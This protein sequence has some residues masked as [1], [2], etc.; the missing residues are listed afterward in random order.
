MTAF[1]FARRQVVWTKCVNPTNCLSAF[2]VAEFAL[3]MRGSRTV[4]VVKWR[5]ILARLWD[6]PALA[7]RPSWKCAKKSPRSK[8]L[9]L[10][11]P[12]EEGGGDN[13]GMS[14]SRFRA[15]ANNRGNSPRQLHFDIR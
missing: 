12:K 15:I 3:E 4:A 5:A 9:G 13:R 7:M 1:L 6:L 8:D 11:P 14:G 2:Y 10:N